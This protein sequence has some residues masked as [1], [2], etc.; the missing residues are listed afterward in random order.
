MD[1]LDQLAVAKMES[2]GKPIDAA[3]EDAAPRVEWA[4]KLS[5]FTPAKER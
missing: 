4:E 1:W 3:L 2:M 5:E